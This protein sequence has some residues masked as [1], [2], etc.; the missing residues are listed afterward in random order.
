[1]L[2]LSFN[3]QVGQW[4]ALLVIGSRLLSV[5]LAG[6]AL[7]TIRHRATTLDFD[8]LPGVGARL[9]V[10]TAALAVGGL[11]MLGV[12]LTAGFPGHWTVLRLLSESGSGWTWLLLGAALA[13]MIGFLR[14]L[15]VMTAPADSD[16]VSRVE[17]E[18][19]AVMVFLLLLIAVSLALGVAPHLAEPVL[20]KLV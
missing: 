10:T 20:A 5:L 7:A 6:A 13:G 11:A 3:T 14:A 15:A 1:L 12:P 17:K 16:Q 18:P 19:R 8:G 2:A 4:A 9:P